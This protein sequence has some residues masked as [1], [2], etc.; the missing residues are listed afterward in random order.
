M[1]KEPDNISSEMKDL[2]TK[3]S[4]E[5]GTV[6]FKKNILGG[7]KEKDVEEYIASITQQFSRTEEA[8]KDRMEEFATHTEMLIKE[9]DDALEQLQ[10]KASEMQNLKTESTA[11]K[12]EN[13]A[14]AKSLEES[15][16][17]ILELEK[18]KPEPMETDSIDRDLAKENEFLKA[19]LLE[20]QQARDQVAG[21]NAVYKKQL[22]DTEELLAATQKERDSLK[23]SHALQRSTVR[24]AEMKK[25]LIVREYTEKQIYT[26][27]QTTQKMAEILTSLEGMKGDFRELLEGLGDKS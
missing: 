22:K 17:Q 16:S 6:K 21:E 20:L 1:N 10:I 18:D 15:Q 11:L 3:T 14:L 23:E 25:G 24:Q 9:C 5:D 19:E 26:M 27:N 4:S 8:Y 2:R 12:N 13:A 7:I